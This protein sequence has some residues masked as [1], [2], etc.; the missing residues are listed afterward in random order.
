MTFDQHLPIPLSGNLHSTYFIK[1]KCFILKHSTYKFSEMSISNLKHVHRRPRPISVSISPSRPS[2]CA[3]FLRGA[4]LQQI[5]P[6]LET[7][8]RQPFL[9]LN[10]ISFVLSCPFFVFS[11]G[12]ILYHT[13]AVCGLIRV[14]D[15]ESTTLSLSSWKREWVT[16]FYSLVNGIFV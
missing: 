2:S 12:L 7:V 16:L 6:L 10:L 13:W 15:L 5:L 4:V 9:T 1:K 14:S 8:S 11:L 3:L